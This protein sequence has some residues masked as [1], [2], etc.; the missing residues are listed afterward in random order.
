MTATSIDVTHRPG[1][2]YQQAFDWLAVCLHA[3]DGMV[4]YGAAAPW[5]WLELA[6]RLPHT[7]TLSRAPAARE[8]LAALGLAEAAPASGLLAAVGLVEPAEVGPALFD[9]LSADGR[10]HVVTGGRLARFLAERRGSAAASPMSARELAASARTAGF[11]VVERLGIHPPAAVWQHYAGEAVL[12]LGRR[13]WRDRRHCAMRR[14][15]VVGGPAA[16][17][18]AL[19]CLT[20]ERDR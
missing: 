2:A 6:H 5:Q 9:R 13:D 8:A 12:A 18:S 11:H 3:A 7:A 16:S 10:L 19:V 20:L 14:D 1:L 15:F 17:W 4:A